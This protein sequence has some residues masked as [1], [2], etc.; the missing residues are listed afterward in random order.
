MFPAATVITF[1]ATVSKTG[2]TWDNAGGRNGQTWQAWLDAEQNFET[3]KK[4]AMA[5]TVR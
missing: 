3:D 2:W 5:V 1:Q 4:F